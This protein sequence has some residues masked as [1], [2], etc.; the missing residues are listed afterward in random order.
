MN[1]KITFNNS[2]KW[3]EAQIKYNEQKLV[4][5]SESKENFKYNFFTRLEHEAKTIVDIFD[6]AF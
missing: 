6:P 5:E 3:L 4:N 2:R 1:N